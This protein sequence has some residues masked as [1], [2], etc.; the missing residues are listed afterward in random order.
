M[1]NTS[2]NSNA[3]QIHPL[4]RHLYGHHARVTFEELFV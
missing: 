1:T 3:P 2:G 4:P